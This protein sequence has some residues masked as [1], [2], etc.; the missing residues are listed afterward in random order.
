MAA[1]G[2]SATAGGGG[3]GNRKNEVPHCAV[4]FE[5]HVTHRYPARG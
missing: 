5:N 4:C 2:R 1:L 3:G